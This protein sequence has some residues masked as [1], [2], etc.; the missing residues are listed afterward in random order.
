MFGFGGI[1]PGCGRVSHC[2]AMNG[3]IYDPEVQGIEGLVATYKN[4]IQRC[5]LN[6]P[7]YFHELLGYTNSFV[8]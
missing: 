3:N 7:T 6:G 1:P 5:E 2:F 8:S 4:A